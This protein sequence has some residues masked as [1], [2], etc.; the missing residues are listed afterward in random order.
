M[1]SN[2]NPLESQKRFDETSNG[3]KQLIT[4]AK[5][6]CLIPSEEEPK[7]SLTAAL[8]LFYSLKELNK[9][10]NLI[11]QD[12]PEKFSFLIPSLDFITSPKNFVISIPK[13]LANISQIYYEKNEQ[14]LKI[15]LTVDKGRI[16]KE[17]VLFYFSDAKPDI[18]ITL[19]IKELQ[20]QLKNQLDAFGFILDV[21]ILNI[22]SRESLSMAQDEN[23][24][25]GAINLIEKKS[26]SETV[27]EII[28]SID[29][30]L[31]K[32]SSANCILTGLIIYYENFKNSKTNPEVFE[33]TA[34]LIKKGADYQQIID[35]IYKTTEKEIIFLSKIFQELKTEGDEASVAIL[36]FDDFQDFTVKE[37]GV[38]IEKI[39]TIGIENDLLVLW[40]S[41]SSTPMTKGFFYSKKQNL[42]NKVAKTTKNTAKNDWVFLSIDESDVNLVK[43]QII[44]LISE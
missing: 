16:K 34:H 22:D 28:K 26:I 25:F 19:G 27:L 33:T 13:D 1:I 42:I 2:D 35:S 32:K 15:H 12:F 3:A 21:P 37:A 24:K 18:V 7:E 38:A 29:E 30:N 10:V 4:K 44:S 17:D 11:I 14:N 23:K 8:A 5:N 6:I 41:H 39:K 31:I 43:E 40:K 20:S 9:N 36:D